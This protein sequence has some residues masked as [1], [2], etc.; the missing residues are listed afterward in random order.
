[1]RVMQ[2]TD[3]E[4]RQHVAEQLECIAV[5][6][7]CYRVVNKYVRFI[8]DKVDM[9]AK[10]QHWNKTVLLYAVIENIRLGGSFSK[11]IGRIDKH[12]E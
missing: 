5:Y 6:P 9:V 8:K 7:A 4:W 11:C 12:D 2:I 3:N 1:M 10:R